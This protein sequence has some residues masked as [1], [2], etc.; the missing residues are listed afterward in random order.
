MTTLMCKCQNCRELFYDFE[1]VRY[2]ES[3]GEILL[4]SPCC[5]DGWDEVEVCDCCDAEIPEDGYDYDD[6]GNRICPEC[7]EVI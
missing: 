7:G 3:S 2:R 4:G 6:D 5:L 1:T